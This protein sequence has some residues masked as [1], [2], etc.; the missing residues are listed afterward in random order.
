VNGLQP[1]Q[2]IKLWIKAIGNYACETSDSVKVIATTLN[3]FGD[4]IYI[5]N[6]FTPNG[7]G[8]N[9]LFQVYGNTIETMRLVIYNQWGQELFIT[10]DRQ[11]GWDGIYKGNQSPAGRYSYALEVKVQN[12]NKITK[13]GSFNLIR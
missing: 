4:G 2:T 13:A 3:P 10:T 5:P 11:K 6:V 9:D 8:V 1:N 7:D 12:G